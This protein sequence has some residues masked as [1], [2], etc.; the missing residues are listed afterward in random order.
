MKFS[1]V[2]AGILTAF[3]LIACST[4]SSLQPSPVFSNELAKQYKG[5]SVNNTPSGYKWSKDEYFA[6]K[7]QRAANGIDVQP[8]RPTSWNIPREYR[9]ELKNAYDMLQ[10]AL[11]PDRKKV[12]KPT[13]AADAQV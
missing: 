9:P 6:K 3:A 1:P 13:A 11:V 12:L 4:M 2:F 5:L 8:E 10:I 7:G